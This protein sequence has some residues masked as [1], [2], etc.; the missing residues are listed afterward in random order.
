MYVTTTKLAH[1]R[2]LPVLFM[3]PARRPSRPISF[4]P[5]SRLTMAHNITGTI[6]PYLAHSLDSMSVTTTTTGNAKINS[7]KPDPRQTSPKTS[8]SYYD[9]Q[10]I[11]QDWG[12]NLTDARPLLPLASFFLGDLRDGLPM[13]N[14]QAACK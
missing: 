14:M 6:P 3:E 13:L 8:S 1:F 7:V 5:F 10:T 4:S 9:E 2:R 12:R 11:T